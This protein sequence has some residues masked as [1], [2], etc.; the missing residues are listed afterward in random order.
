MIV[1][2]EEFVGGD[3]W[4]RAV[5]LG[6]GDAIVM[7]LA[8]KCYASQHPGTEGFIPEED[9]GDLPGA[10]KSAR[11]ALRALVDC[12]RL[13]PDGSRGPGLVEHAEGGW[14]LHD[15]LDHSV[16]PEEIELRRER[17]RLKKA[18]YREE[19]R[20]ELECLRA[21]DAPRSMSPGDTG[22]HPGDTRG[23]PGDTSEGDTLTGA[24]PHAPAPTRGRARPHSNPPQPSQPSLSSEERE[25]SLRESE[26]PS[27]GPREQ[28]WKCFPDGWRGWSLATTA[29]AV[30]LGL[31]PDDL[32][33]HVDY[34]SLRDFPGG[35]V[36]D[37]DGELRRGLDGIAK[38]KGKTASS[39]PPPLAADPYAW[40]PI[41]AHRAFAKAHELDLA[42]AAAAYRTAKVPDRLG[43]LKANDDFMRRLEWWAENGG[44]FR[45]VGPLPRRESSAP[46]TRKAVG[47]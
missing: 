1:I 12:G 24:R 23:T 8:L 46:E 25:L 41:A 14:R 29:A 21:L 28:R 19:K 27:S 10:P 7:W 15:Y 31:T 42:I 37:L 18:R 22:G 2:K 38:R 6:C 44:E 30:A 3:K 33:G 47:A 4:R 39:A 35:S 40:A 26:P 13:L 11:K 43:T 9:I 17:A 16:T 36:N 45:A 20:R 5:K 34:W 32:A